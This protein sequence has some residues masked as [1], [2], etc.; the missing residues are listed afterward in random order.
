MDPGHGLHGLLELGLRGLLASE[1]P[2]LESYLFARQAPHSANGD[3]SQLSPQPNL[4]DDPRVHEAMALPA[5]GRAYRDPIATYN[6]QVFGQASHVA[7]SLPNS[8]VY[9]AI[10]AHNGRPLDAATMWRFCRASAA[11]C[12]KASDMA[13]Q[14]AST[15]K[16]PV[17]LKPLQLFRSMRTHARVIEA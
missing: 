9:A 1:Q 12:K 14:V 4:G 3:D 15:A 16:V 6:A 13:N 10:C 7:L 8:D 11:Q 5:L 2:R 17:A